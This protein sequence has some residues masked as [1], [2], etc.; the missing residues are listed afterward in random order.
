MQRRPSLKHFGLRL[1]HNALN[2]LSTVS[3]F[4]ANIAQLRRAAT[5]RRDR[6]VPSRRA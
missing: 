3:S 4:V 6:T 5:A 1:L 2:R